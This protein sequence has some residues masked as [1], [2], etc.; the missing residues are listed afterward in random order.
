MIR[1]LIFVLL[2]LIV[3]LSFSNIGTLDTILHFRGE[4]Y[5]IHTTVFSA[6]I[7]LLIIVLCSMFT[8]KLIFGIFNL[9]SLIQKIIHRNKINKNQL[10]IIDCVC[11]LLIDNKIKA[12]K[13]VKK[14]LLRTSIDNISEEYQAIINI[15]AFHCH[16]N[17]DKK[18]QYLNK[19]KTSKHYY[20]FAT[21]NLAKIFYQRSLYEEA[22]QYAIK[23]FDVNEVD[24]EIL[25]ILLHCYGKLQLWIKF[26]F[27]ISK[28][29][30]MSIKKIDK[31]KYIIADYYV[32][33]AITYLQH[34]EQN[35]KKYLE[36]ALEINHGSVD[37]LELYCSLLKKNNKRINRKLLDNAFISNP[38]FKIAKLYIQY[39]NLTPTQTYQQLS[40]LL[41][42][43][44]Y[45][46]IF[47]TISAYL[48]LPNTL[49]VSIKNK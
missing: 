28:I 17:F 18:I 22:E 29:Q 20:Y 30:R 13:L 33:A 16:D 32:K 3:Y 37:A 26:M 45:V 43:Q 21:K 49:N 8:I 35:T 42:P 5:S 25:E 38:S 48:E 39:L 14:I 36:L 11:Y 47:L 9:P 2:L 24:P 44:K 19:L 23:A 10:L 4:D 27:I 7:M 1:L 6:I 46:D 40:K 31:M 41:D 12:M 15:I 34:D